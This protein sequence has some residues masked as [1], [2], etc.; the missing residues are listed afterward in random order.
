MSNRR[1]P[2]M[3]AVLV[4]AAALLGAVNK[5]TIR[6]S[7]PLVV[8]TAVTQNVESCYTALDDLSGFDLHSRGGNAT[9]VTFVATESGTT[10]FTVPAG[11]VWSVDGMLIKTGETICFQNAGATD[12]IEL[13]VWR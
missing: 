6:G 8:N 7:D 3:L 10:Y 2:I 1:I 12:T 13:V 9:K 11:G 4:G 5:G